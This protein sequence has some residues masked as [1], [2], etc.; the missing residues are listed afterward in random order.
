[1]GKK[2]SRRAFL[3]Q[4]GAA[5][6]GGALT[7]CQQ[8]TPTPGNPGTLPPVDLTSTPT[9]QPEPAGTIPAFHTRSTPAAAQDLPTQPAQPTPTSKTVRLADLARGVGIDIG[10][11]VRITDQE[12]LV[13]PRYL[14]ALLRFSLISDSFANQFYWSDLH[15]GQ[16]FAYL[17]QVSTFCKAR[18]R[19]FG[20][21]YLFSPWGHFQKDSK[22]YHLLSAS[23]AE[24]ETW[25]IDRLKRFLS[26][27][28]VTSLVVTNNPIFSNPQQPGNFGWV[29]DYNPFYQ[30]FG[31]EWVITAFRMA[32]EQAQKEGKKPGKELRLVYQTNHT[33]PG[34]PVINFEFKLLAALV[35][36]LS[37]SFGVGRP[38]DI[39]LNFPVDLQPGE[40][41]ASSTVASALDPATL[42]VFFQRLGQ[43][44]DVRIS[45]FRISGVEDP[46]EQR[47]VLRNVLEACLQSKVCKS[48]QFAAP[49]NAGAQP[50]TAHTKIPAVLN[51]NYQPDLLYQEAQSVLERYQ[52]K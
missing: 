42:I 2:I 26:L 52:G 48:F 3:W 17:E 23:R 37:K 12:R 35:E 36:N 22:P 13:D 7:A 29:E 30:M 10:A 4:A 40:T 39:S 20:V 45:G 9:L 31:P 6:L 1:M 25:M 32:W 24:V 50:A 15:T 43:L 16:T 34:T 38:I 44:G 5:F 27:P 19:Q 47:L 33:K 51:E 11:M 41:L 46:Q 21:E 18:Q 14:D 49:L 28:H 8:I